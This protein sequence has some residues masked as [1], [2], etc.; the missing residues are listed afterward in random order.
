[1]EAGG[2]GISAQN[3]P[4]S[5]PLRTR[6]TQ[7]TRLLVECVHPN[8]RDFENK[9][10][11]CM[12]ATFDRR[13]CW[14][15]CVLEFP[16]VVY[17]TLVIDGVDTSIDGVDT[18]SL[19]LE[20]FHEDRVYIAL[21]IDG[22]DTSIDGV[23]TGS[24]FL[25]LFHEDRVQCVD[26]APG[27]VDTRPSSQETQLPDWDRVSTQSLVVSTLDPASRRPF[28]DNWDSVSRH[29]VHPM[30]EKAKSILEEGKKSRKKESASRGAEQRRQGKKKEKTK[31]KKR[32]SS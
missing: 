17:T 11:T 21:V 22:V 18:G 28:L 27:N 20:L 15:E 9:A 7:T 16:K 5:V 25:E 32:R 26:I 23:D 19:F 4:L 12:D 10:S 29:S 30:Q 3:R 31:K 24:L 8:R 14:V 1:W 2:L 6:L 13:Y